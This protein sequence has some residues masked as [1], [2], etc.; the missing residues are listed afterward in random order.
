MS[1]IENRLYKSKSRSR[2]TN[3][4]ATIEI[5]VSNDGDLDPSSGLKVIRHSQNLDI[6]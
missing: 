5:Q 2:K 4:K 6:F 1:F 3:L